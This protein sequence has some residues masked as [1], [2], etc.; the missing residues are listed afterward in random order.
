MVIRWLLG[1]GLVCNIRLILLRCLFCR[2]MKL[3]IRC[4]CMLRLGLVLRKLVIV[5]VRWWWLKGIGVL[6]WIRF[7]G[8]VFRDIVLVWVRCSLVMICWVWLVKVRLVGVV[9]IVWVVCISRVLLMVCFRVFIWCVMVD[10]VSG[11]LCV[12]VEKLLLS[13]I[14]R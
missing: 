8:V 10:G 4:N 14:S 6:I 5:G 11:C 9:C 13:R 12:V 1:S 3:L 7:C 2:L